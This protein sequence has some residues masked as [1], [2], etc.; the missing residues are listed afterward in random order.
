MT[1]A[2][3]SIACS[4]EKAIGQG[5]LLLLEMHVAKELNRKRALDEDKGVRKITSV[6]SRS[7]MMLS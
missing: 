4:K 5:L 6:I 1:R 2:Q 7:R 3:H